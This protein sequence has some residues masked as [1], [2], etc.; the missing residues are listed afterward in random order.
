M[1][2]YNKL[3][4]DR[5]PQIIEFTGKDFNIKILN[6]YEYKEELQWKLKEELQEYFEAEGDSHSIEE[7]ADI[8]ELIHA[9][10]T[11]HHSSYEELEKVRNEKKEKRGGFEERIYLIDVED[12]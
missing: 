4:R 2:V 5:I 10:S 7:L 11:V 1:P 9:L 6:D 8:L 3:I 12:E